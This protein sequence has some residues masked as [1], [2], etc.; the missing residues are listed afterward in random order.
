MGGGPCGDALVVTAPEEDAMVVMF[1]K[2]DGEKL[3]DEL[4]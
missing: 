1:S 3:A 4:A 2:L